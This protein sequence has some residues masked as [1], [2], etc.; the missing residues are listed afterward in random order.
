[1]EPTLTFGVAK[2]IIT[3]CFPM[4]MMGFGSVYGIPFEAI[5]DD[6]YARTLVLTDP[7]GET[8]ILIALDLLFHDDS[9]PNA[10]REYAGARYGIPA[11]SLHVTYTHTHYG[12]AVKG[13]D[14]IYW[15]QEYEDFLL[16]RV[17][18]CIDRAFLNRCEGTVEYGSVSGMWNIS[19]RLPTDQGMEFLPNPSGDRDDAV[20]F[21]KFRALDGSIR[22]L[23]MNFACHPSNINQYRILTS[24]YPGRLCQIMEARHYGC[25]ALFFQGC[26][27]D[28]KLRVGAKGSRFTGLDYAECE[29]T[30][31]SMAL[32][33]DQALFEGRAVPV[34]PISLKSCIFQ[35]PLPLDPYP[36]TFFE[37]ERR[38]HSGGRASRFDRD[39]F[40]QS[41][42]HRLHWACDEYVL[43]RY[44][45]LPE[46]LALNCGIIS[47]TPDFYIFS[48]GGEPSCDVKRV[49]E[50][51]VP[52]QTMLFFG[53]NDAI[54]YIPSD[55]MIREGGYEASGR[56]VPEYRLKGSFRAGIDVRFKEA[57]SKNLKR[58]FSPNYAKIK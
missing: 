3:P 13:Y 38:I 10:L 52:D 43:D 45:D 33:I 11:G 55:K 14:F 49:L 36:R 5:H 44:D 20:Y 26:G 40:S 29:E 42:E 23:A 47:L 37:E 27:G 46:E 56:S 24:E 57:F 4:T 18:Q 32:R 21:L 9:L 25:T 58:L 12:P 48:M 50:E 1:M 51:I 34:A 16:Q 31:Q 53:Y 39:D 8:V 35:I 6:L 28:A 17:I 7:F 19:R 54:A 22:A 15:K 41:N 30:A 2:E